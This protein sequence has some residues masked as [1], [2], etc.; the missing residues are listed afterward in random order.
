MYRWLRAGK[1]WANPLDTEDGHPRTH[2]LLLALNILDSNDPKIQDVGVHA[3]QDRQSWC[4]EPSSVAGHHRARDSVISTSDES[5]LSEN[6]STNGKALSVQPPI[7]FHQVRLVMG[8]TLSSVYDGCLVVR[9]YG[10]PSFC[11]MNLRCASAY[12]QR[13]AKTCDS[14]AHSHESQMLIYPSDS[15]CSCEIHADRSVHHS[16]GSRGR[17]SAAGSSTR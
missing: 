10:C 1:T 17:K 14:L 11:F 8:K 13:S 2:D 6:E 16:V 9:C 3:G 12:V 5:V 7:P 15:L 4:V